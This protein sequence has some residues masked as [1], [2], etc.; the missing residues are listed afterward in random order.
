M[1]SIGCNHLLLHEPILSF[2]PTCWGC[3]PHSQLYRWMPRDT[4]SLHPKKTDGWST[5]QVK[6]DSYLNRMALVAGLGRYRRV[7]SI[8]GGRRSLMAVLTPVTSSAS[9]LGAANACMQQTQIKLPCTAIG[10]CSINPG[11]STVTACKKNNSF[12]CPHSC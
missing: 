9:L 5:H 8:A 10:F 6:C 4:S 3:L 11:M 7:L 2:F 12:R 1:P